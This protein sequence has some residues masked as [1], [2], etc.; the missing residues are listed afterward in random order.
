MN[1]C[2]CCGDRW[3]GD[4]EDHCCLGSPGE[5]LLRLTPKGILIAA[6]QDEGLSADAGSRIWDMLEAFCIKQACD[7]DYAALIF[8]GE[9]GT[10]M[11][12]TKEDSDA[13]HT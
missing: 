12:A 7:S 10:V 5:K 9:G 1:E 13:S 6:V 8:D 2:P 4:P 3:I 11:G